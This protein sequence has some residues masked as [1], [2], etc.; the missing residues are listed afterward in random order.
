MTDCRK[1][2]LGEANN[3]SELEFVFMLNFWNE[4]LE[5]FHQTSQLLQ[6][7]SVILQTC[8]DLYLSLA[9]QLHTSGDEFE[10]FESLA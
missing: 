3:I 6:S 4:T 9:Y 2:T 5:K 1:V 7:E 8:A 10:R